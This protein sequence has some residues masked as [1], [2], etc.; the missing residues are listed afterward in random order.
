MATQT[1]SRRPARTSAGDVAAAKARA[2]KLAALHERL[3]AEVAALRTGE[4][5]QRWLTTASRF[6]TYSF[7]NVL[8]IQSQRPDATLVAGYEAWKAFGRHVVKGEK[9]IAILAPI[10]RRPEKT[11]DARPDDARDDT[12]AGPPATVAGYRVTYV[13]DLAQTS[14][15]PLP[16]RQ[17]PT[18]LQGQAPDG[19]WEALADQIARQGFTLQRGDGGGANGI[20]DYLARTVRVREDLDDA[21]AVKTVA[22]ELGHVVLHRPEDGDAAVRCRGVIEVEA[23]SVAYLVTAVH[24]LDSSGYTFPYVTTWATHVPDHAA[25]DVVRDSGQRVITAAG[26]ILDRTLPPTMAADEHP[27]RLRELAERTEASAL[28]TADLRHAA[29]TAVTNSRDSVAATPRTPKPFASKHAVEPTRAELL[30]VHAEA[31]AFYRAQLPTSWV[32]DY[33]DQRSLGAALDATWAAGYAPAR[34]TGLVDHLRSLGAGDQLLLAS[35]LATTARNGRLIDRFRDRLV[36]SLRD[37]HGV[38]AFIGRTHPTADARTP[39]YLNSPETP[40]YRKGEHLYGLADARTALSRGARPVLVEGPL[41]ALAVTTGTQGRCVG[42]AA[43]GTAFTARHLDQ[44]TAAADL[45]RSGLVVATDPDQAGRAAAD[46][47]LT[48]ISEKQLTA[49]EARLPTGD[50]ADTLHHHGPAALTTALLDDAVRLA[51]VVIDAR[52]D[53]WGDDLRWVEGRIGAVRDVAPLVAGLPAGEAAR[54]AHRIAARVDVDVTTVAREVAACV[55]TARVGH[56]ERPH[57]AARSPLHAAPRLPR[58]AA[59]GTT[60]RFAR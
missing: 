1:R 18:L 12:T 35:G 43:C 56:P 46:R 48:L 57:A 26:H 31:A 10:I 36:L 29:E 7:T 38:I 52:I 30:A 37:E 24:G 25:E 55:G 6:H 33:L 2:D 20:T 41:D 49:T 34:W 3:A 11:D 14:G 51:D 54:Q 27:E 16:E 59:G 28:R 4:D 53:A 60:T 8:L 32:P 44:L 50:P 15:Q 40:L 47:L 23:E 39:R 9:G 13:W 19:L 21:H 45:T 17:K 5:W 58:L 22:D 42:L